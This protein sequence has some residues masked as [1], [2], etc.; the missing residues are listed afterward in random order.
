[1]SAI[2]PFFLDKNIMSYHIIAL[3]LRAMPQKYS[4]LNNL[5]APEECSPTKDISCQYSKVAGTC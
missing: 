1:M 4:Y 2:G 3:T 5:S